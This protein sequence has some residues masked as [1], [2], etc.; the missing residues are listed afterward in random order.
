M[1]AVVPSE[2]VEIKKKA[3]EEIL[4]S[5]NLELHKIIQ[6]MSKELSKKKDQ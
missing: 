3:L 5:S 1:K 4:L 2:I 6:A